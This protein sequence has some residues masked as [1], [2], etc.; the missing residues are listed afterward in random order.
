MVEERNRVTNM[1][2]DLSMVTG[3]EGAFQTVGIVW[4]V[5]INLRPQNEQKHRSWIYEA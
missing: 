3:V 5:R 2:R 4:E 1:S